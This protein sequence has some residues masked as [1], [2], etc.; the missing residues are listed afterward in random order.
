MKVFLLVLII[1]GLLIGNTAIQSITK[2]E[3]KKVDTLQAI[4]NW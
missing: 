1:L 3:N 2:I 4:Y